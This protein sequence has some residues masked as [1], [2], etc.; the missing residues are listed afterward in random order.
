M[1]VLCCGMATTFAQKAVTGVVTGN[2]GD[3]LIGASVIAT[4]TNVGTITD[5]DGS[6][7]LTVPAGVTSLQVS[8]TGF[9]SQE[10]ALGEGSTYNITLNEGVE[11][12]EIVVTASGIKR[13]SRDV[14]Y[15]NQTVSSEDLLSTPNKNTL[16]A[17]RGKTSGVRLSTGSGSVG[18]STRI[19]LRGEG[20]LT[21][22]NNALIVVDG[23]P[24]NNE[25]AS[26]GAGTSTTGYAD[27]G[28]RFNDINPDDIE[29]VTILKGPSA[30]S[31]YGSRGAS[32][33]VLITTKKGG[34]G[35]DGKVE[36][37][38]N[39]SYS[40]E[41]AYVLLQRQDQFGQGYDNAHFDSGENWAWGP[42]FDGVPRPWT[43]PIDADGDGSLES[44]VR[45]FS[46]APNQLQEFFNIG[47]TNNNGFY[48]SGANGGFTYYA[49]YANTIQNGILDNSSYKRHTVTFNSSAKLTDRLSSEFK[50]TYA[51]IDQ[52]TAQEGS[53]AFEGNNA[54]A[55][56]VQSPVNI[57]FGELR[58]YNNPFHDI[59]GYW[60]S[61]SSV[62]PYFI[63][64]EYG[65]EGRINNFLGNAALTYNLMEGLD[66]IGRFG[67]NVVTTG[68]QT[69]TPVFFPETQLVWGD[70]FSLTSRNTKHESAGAYSDFSRQDVNLDFTGLANYTRAIN[71]NINF[72]AS[73]GYNWFQKESNSITGTTN[74]GLVVPGWYNLSNSASASSSTQNRTQ[75]RLYG[76][77][78][79][80]R[81]GYKNAL[82]LEYSAR[83]DWSSTLPA[84]NNSFFYNAFGA[85]AIITDLA[86]I[87]SDALSF[88]KARAS[89]GTSG[90][91][92]GL[93]LLRSSFEGN[94]QVVNLGGYSLQF[95]LNGQPGFTTGNT[96]GNA[97]LRPELT[98]TFEVGADVGLFSDR[99]NL[100]Y[101]YY[102]ASHSDQIVQ[103]SLPRS[104]GFTTTVSNIGEMTNKGHELTLSVKP[105]EG[106]VKGLD[107]DVF[108]TWSK[109]VN[110]VVKI[111]D[112]IEE[113]TIGGPYTP[114]VS[115][116]A[117]EG[118]PFGTYK[119]LAPLTNDAGQTVVDP[120]TGFPLYTDEEQYLGSYQPDYIASFGTNLGYKG[121]GFNILFDV[122]QGGSFVSQ[123]K[124]F[125]EFNGTAAHTA[126]YNREAYVFPNS[127]I[128]NG[129]GT[130]SENTIEITEQDYFTNYDPASSTYIIDASFVKLREI[131]LSYA[132]PR[133]V[134]DRVSVSN[135]QISLYAQNVKFWLPDDN[136]FAD[137]EVN[138]PALTGNAS[139][140]ETTQTPPA[141]SLG[142]A[143][144]LTF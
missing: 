73:V 38:V 95:P 86:G 106:M 102:S 142:V 16:Q 128:D 28:N 90:K 121:I 13:N 84:E 43:S 112:D 120:N 87:D 24:I 99:I 81:L 75:Y 140:I 138:G 141:Q 129:D 4:G 41:K 50:V 114:G 101:T 77:L 132:I 136:I 27:H 74:G 58:D 127:V 44:L 6:F 20:S 65:N 31:L 94:P 14:V 117:K 72:D 108:G 19:V 71:E 88:L 2:S 125:T 103:I 26:G 21:G 7:S 59:N 78:A 5:L 3:P 22:D 33:V 111:T 137:P 100:A 42:A 55:M 109:N 10:V 9:I 143:L 98:T 61:Y 93:Y 17:L 29:S 37:G 115:V 25:S 96:I 36:V 104:T 35:R 69:W 139:G 48:L 105:I 34:N 11:L 53:R 97:D 80:L 118:L 116:V 23:I 15:A 57:P 119:A 45:P 8:Y 46:A 144:R 67:S 64:N 131:G 85:S 40:Y 66:L 30:T 126:E 39:T 54:Y 76:V 83:N 107:W 130:Y 134:C 133:S 92:A 135:A 18:A 12:S 56:A 79:N 113:L 52:N 68:I 123:T 60:G 1:L 51:N 124:F 122:R 110:E 63:L 89:Y 62:N 82:F 49:S 47:N 32:G 70:D 91:D